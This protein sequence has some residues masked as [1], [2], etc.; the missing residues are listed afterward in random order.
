M[1]DIKK[2]EYNLEYVEKDLENY[3]MVDTESGLKRLKAR[4]RI[5]YLDKI[6]DTFHKGGWLFNNDYKNGK[7]IIEGLVK[8]KGRPIR[9]SVTL[10]NIIVFTRDK[11]KNYKK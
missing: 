1:G 2:K 5:K 4:S 3:R 6:K 7:Y 8:P 11:R 10:K 9:W